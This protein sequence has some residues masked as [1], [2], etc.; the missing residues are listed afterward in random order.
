MLN[1]GLSHAPLTR[2]AGIAI[3]VGLVALT[4]PLA[5]LGPASDVSRS[6][7]SQPGVGA[8]LPTISADRELQA[9][10]ASEL[11]ATGR[12]TAS[13]H[14]VLMPQIGD[15]T[16]DGTILRWIRK[17]G[18]RVD[19]DDPLFEI[20]TDKGNAEV[21]S[22]AAG[23]LVEMRARKG[24]K[25]P[26]NDVV[27]VIGE[28]RAPGSA[29]PGQ[30]TMGPAASRTPG[31]FATAGYSGTLKD[32]TGRPMPG[33]V[34]LVNSATAQRMEMKLDGSGQFSANGLPTGEYQVEASKP[35][36]MTIRKHVVLAAGQHLREDLVA[37]IGSLSEMVVVQGGGPATAN[38]APA[39]PRPHRNPAE[40]PADPCAQSVIGG[41]I[42]PPM[43]LV[44]M[45]PAFPWAHATDGASGTVVIEGR[46]GTDGF[47]KEMKANDGADPAFAE[48]ALEAV[49][50]WQFSPVRLN[51][52]PVE[53]RIEVTVKFVTGDN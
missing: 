7:L 49:R 39:A 9:N 12:Q 40:P 52:T 5:G 43:K 41:C 46:V 25:V 1:T 3:V 6:S 28:A 8:T 13:G 31:Q 10:R 20:S 27:A 26:V 17:I 21:R 35:G 42:T 15:S 33:V 32:P 30:P 11:S 53:C 19:R 14:S 44:E 50:Q 47:V 29:G 51:S 38:A 37:Q 48:S 18:D 16:T 2:M 4:V 23:V 22:P 24:D 34:A 36:F 45:K